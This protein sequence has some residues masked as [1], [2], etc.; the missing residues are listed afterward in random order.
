MIRAALI[1]VLIS[2]CAGVVGEVPF[3]A[4]EMLIDA[5][6]PDAAVEDAG[7]IE[8]AGIPDAGEVI[9]AGIPD[10]G[11]VDAG[12]PLSTDRADFFGTSRCADAGFIFCE[13]FEAPTL[14][15]SRWTTVGGSAVT[16]SN[17]D[18]ARGAQAL[19]VL[20]VGNG[21]AFVRHTASFPMLNNSYFG[22]LFIKFVQMPKPPM[23]YS[24]W[25]F[26]AASGTVV[27]GEIRLGGQLTSN[28]TRQLF[29]VGTDNR[30]QDAGTGD[31]T[32]SDADPTGMVRQVPLD[33]WLCIEWQ[34]AGATNETRFWW[35]AIEHASLRTTESRHGGNS[36]PFILPQFT[37]FW[38]GWQEYQTSTQT[39]ELWVDEVALSA[40]RIGCVR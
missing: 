14:S 16:V 39:F 1:S 15:T 20:K 13:D 29:G 23:T 6:V 12:N 17:G 34:H 35:D 3:D 4:G 24:H 36:N 40:T 33:E 18:K 8:D 5:S 7:V 26:A 30:T 37:N 28:G 10:A 25:T 32:T 31:W 19:H 2:G 38:V 9:D 11:P 22:R 21:A 27:N